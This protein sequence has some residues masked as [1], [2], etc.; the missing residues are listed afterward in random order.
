MASR[1]IMRVTAIVVFLVGALV[2]AVTANADDVRTISQTEVSQLSPQVVTRRVVDQVADLLTN[3]PTQTFN[4]ASQKAAIAGVAR[5]LGAE[6]GSAAA[7]LSN[8][9]VLKRLAGLLISVPYVR[10]GP[11]K[12]LRALYYETHIHP[13]S[14]TDLCSK[15]ELDVI[16]QRVGDVRG[17]DATVSA[18]RVYVGN[19]YYFLKSPASAVAVPFA[20]KKMRAKTAV[21]CAAL[22]QTKP[23]YVRATN[24]AGVV[25]G[26]W[27]LAAI[28]R[29]AQT[30]ALSDGWTCD[31]STTTADCARALAAEPQSL[32]MM[33]CGP[34]DSRC[35]LI[36]DS[37]LWIDVTAS[38]GDKPAITQLST[39]RLVPV[40]EFFDPDND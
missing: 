33:G 27:L 18:A 21:A 13:T 26:V 30:G 11:P 4:D 8:P 39:R 34:E 38:Q 22:E 35:T 5:M 15:E 17:A 10:Y 3:P 37:S 23:K 2:L 19:L 16:F 1:F 20:A 28:Q 14:V 7:D 25:R 31:K 36:L 32:Q 12:R 9:S 24:D 29:Q 6:P 40:P